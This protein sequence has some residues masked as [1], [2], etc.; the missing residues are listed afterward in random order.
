MDFMKIEA[1]I[2][3]VKSIKFHSQWHLKI[4]QYFSRKKTMQLSTEIHQMD[5][6]INLQYCCRSLYNNH[7]TGCLL[8]SGQAE[9]GA[10]KRS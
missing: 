3:I 2:A 8:S 6:S 4:F 5:I 7:K 9:A 1:L 10:G